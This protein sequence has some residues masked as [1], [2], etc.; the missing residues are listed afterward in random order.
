MDTLRGHLSNVSCALFHPNKPLIISNSEDKTIRVWDITRRVSVKIFRQDHDKDRFWILSSHPDQNLF[1]AGHDSGLIV[2]KLEHERPA[3]CVY[4]DVVY[5]VKDRT[6]FSFNYKQ[7]RSI[8]SLNIR[9]KSGL[10]CGPRSLHF[11]PAENAIL[12]LTVWF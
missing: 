1:A 2:F 10:D 6:L 11:N 7:N 8:A 5:Y 12:V 3:Y 9:R 4:E